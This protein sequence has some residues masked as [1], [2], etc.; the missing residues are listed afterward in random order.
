MKV[1]QRNVLDDNA[2]LKC[3]TPSKKPSLI[4]THGS[5]KSFIDIDKLLWLPKRFLKWE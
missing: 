2:L 5:V 3:N 1:E 4:L